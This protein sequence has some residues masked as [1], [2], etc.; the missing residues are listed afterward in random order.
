M[1]ELESSLDVRSKEYQQNRADMLEM[2]ATLDELYVEAGEGG[3]EEAMER[4]RS[5]GKMPIRERI[6]LVLDRDSPF[7]EISPLAAWKSNSTHRARVCRCILRPA[8]RRRS[9]LPGKSPTA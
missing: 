8:A 4:L 1:P 6:A 5:R 7:L 9:S 2:L 3:G